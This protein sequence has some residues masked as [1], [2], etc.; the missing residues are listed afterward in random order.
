M[1]TFSIILTAAI[2]AILFAAG[3]VN[4]EPAY[5]NEPGTTPAP[6]D[7]TGY[8]SMAGMTMRVIYD[9]QTDTQPDD[10]SGETVKPQTRTEEAQPDVDGFI[11]EIFDAE[12]TSVYKNTYVN[13]RT[14]TAATDGKMELP[15]GSYKLEVRSEEPSS[16]LAEWNHPVYFAARDFAIEKNE[17]TVLEE[18]VCTLNNIKV[19]LTCSK[20]LA[21]QFTAETISTISLGETPMVFV[22]GE[23]RAAY[24]TSLAELNT[25]KFN[26]TGAFA[27]TPETPLQFNKE[28]PN[29]KAGQWRKITLVITYADKGGIKF[30]IDVKNFIMDEE[31]RIDGTAN[32]WEP[33]FEEGPDPLAPAIEWPGHDL[34]E[35]FRITS[36][37]FD[38]DGKCTEP[39][40][41]NLTAPNGIESLVL[42]FSSTNSAFMDALT[43]IQIPHSLDLCATTQGPAY[44]ILSG[45]G[46]PLGDKL[47]GATSKQFDIAGQIPMLYAD[48]GFEGT[49][50]F[51]CTLT[52]AKGLSTSAELRLV[53]SKSSA[54]APSI[55]WVGYEIDEQQPLTHD[56]KIDID[57]Q[58]PAGIK[59]FEVT[60]ISEILDPLL[61]EM[62]IPAQFDLCNLGSETEPLIKELGFPTNEEVRNKTSFDPLFSITDFVEMIFLVFDS[63]GKESGT[64]DFRLSIT[65]NK[66][67]LTTKTIQLKAV[68]EKE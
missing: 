28:I 66:D 1:K 34:T 59:K 45:F 17:D 39:F 38:A 25:L 51:A 23:T 67:Q 24:F 14:E 47:R 68:K 29:V 62:K 57:I 31:I 5:K 63:S 33:V 37:M 21:D 16:K 6:E 50:T 40:A 13:L 35:P 8:L 42:T 54:D 18:I 22:K 32:V 64:F 58:V 56:M 7:G 49:H 9:D 55:K 4:E 44:A 41:L 20:D 2:T 52:D 46:L 3:C 11:V 53:V 10:T 36:S 27:D 48:P 15:T 26:L 61:E 43:E 19:T 12:G 30:D 65:D 60:I